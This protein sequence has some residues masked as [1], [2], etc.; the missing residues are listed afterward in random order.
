MSRLSRFLYLHK[1]EAFNLLFFAFI[2]LWPPRYLNRIPTESDFHFYAGLSIVVALFL[3]FAGIW[4][5]SRFI[6]SSKV[7][8]EKPIPFL[9][10]LAVWPRLLLNVF[11]LLLAFRAMGILSRS[12]FYVLPIV[13]IACLKEFWVRAQLLNPEDS[14]GERDSPFKVWMAEGMLF[15]F[16]CV[17]YVA[18]WEYYLLESPKVLLKAQYLTNFPLVA[19]VFL[20]CLLSIQMPHLLEE[21]LRE[22]PRAQK[23]I[24]GASFLLP[25]VG[26]LFQL[27]YMGF[28]GK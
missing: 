21:Y 1:V 11:T 22:K 3:E 10:R 26:L 7:M 8:R 15:I 27:F 16:A 19:A 13:A 23:I 25:V 2:M 5:K 4:Y 6:F 20:L 9:F 12:D 28:L 17:A 14:E 18:L 24:A